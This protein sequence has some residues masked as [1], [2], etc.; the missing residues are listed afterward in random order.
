[1][2]GL[3]MRILVCIRVELARTV[4]AGVQQLACMRGH[5][6][7]QTDRTLEHLVAVLAL[8][9]SRGVNILSVLVQTL[10][11]VEFPIAY[12]AS[13]QIVFV[14][15][16]QQV[17]VQGVPVFHLLA[18]YVASHARR[19]CFHVADFVRLESLARLERPGAN[20]AHVT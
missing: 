3:L 10:F 13:V 11:A 8:E 15:V 5:V 7:L 16:S 19:R 20:L 2:L 4:G 9:L 14:F 17:L 12:F 18:A 1:M 6:F